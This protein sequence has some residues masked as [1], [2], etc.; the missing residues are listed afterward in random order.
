LLRHVL[1]KLLSNSIQYSPDGTTVLCEVAN[2]HA[3][4]LLV[5]VQDSGIGITDEDSN[6]AARAFQGGA[7]AGSNSAIGLALTSELTV[8]IAVRTA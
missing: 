4:E 3:A 7:N 2:Q 8:R 5:R 1:E 6:A